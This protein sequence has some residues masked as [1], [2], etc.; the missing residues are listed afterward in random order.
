MTS[1]TKQCQK[2]PQNV[3]KAA[4]DG[5]TEILDTLKSDTQ[6]KILSVQTNRDVHGL[7]LHFREHSRGSAVTYA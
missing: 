5:L 3:Q 7:V 2:Q 1:S 6:T 4:L